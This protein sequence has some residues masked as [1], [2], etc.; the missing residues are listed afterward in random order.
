MEG[1]ALVSEAIWLK[2]EHWEIRNGAL[3]QFSKHRVEDFGAP[4]T[5]VD[6]GGWAGA[7]MRQ[8][9]WHETLTPERAQQLLDSMK[10]EPRYRHGQAEKVSE[11]LTSGTYVGSTTITISRHDGSLLDGRHR[12]KAVV[13]SGVSFEATVKEHKYQ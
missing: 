8:R 12:C 3:R 10:F 7:V 11:Q 4:L 2:T 6:I 1:C 9:I 5:V 13:L